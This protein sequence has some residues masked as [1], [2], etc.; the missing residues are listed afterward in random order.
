MAGRT[1]PNYPISHGMK[2]WGWVERGQC[3][4]RPRFLTLELAVLTMVLS[5]TVGE[6]WEPEGGGAF[7][8]K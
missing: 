8:C 3:Q 1:N 2:K 5:T 7:G 6:A 4:T